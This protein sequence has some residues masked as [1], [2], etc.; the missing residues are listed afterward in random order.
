MNKTSPGSETSPSRPSFFGEANHSASSPPTKSFTTPTQSSS[1]VLVSSA[2]TSTP[3]SVQSSAKLFNEWTESADP[4]PSASSPSVPATNILPRGP[5]IKVERGTS[6]E[7]PPLGPKSIVEMGAAG[8]RPPLGPKSMA[9]RVSIGDRPPTGPR[10][11]IERVP[12]GDSRHRTTQGVRG[13][14]IDPDD[15]SMATAFLKRNQDKHGA[16][17]KKFKG[18]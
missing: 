17:L 10:S 13:R 12:P 1:K 15:V 18:L 16:A 4:N 14:P 5:K 2:E 11:M 7:R 6:A 8:Q 9:N 3:T